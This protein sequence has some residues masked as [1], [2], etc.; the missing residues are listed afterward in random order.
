MEWIRLNQS[1]CSFLPNKAAVGTA[2]AVAVAGLLSSAGPHGYSAPV[3][4]GTAC[5]VAVAGLL[6]S[7]GPH[8]Y[9]AP[10]SV[11]AA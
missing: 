2:C 4:V 1:C 5:A 9:A 10:V 3:S 7:V 11:A 6:S 8:G